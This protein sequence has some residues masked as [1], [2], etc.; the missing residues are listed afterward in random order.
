MTREREI[1]TE[2]NQVTE[3]YWTTHSEYN[4]VNALLI[5]WEDDELNVVPEVKRLQTLFEKDYR[6]NSAPIYPI[7][8]TNSEAELQFEL[9]RFIRQHSLKR[10]SLTIVYYAGH[11]DSP[12]ES[13][14]GYSK[15]RA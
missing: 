8:T 11:A 3:N 12:D 2:F 9:A 10:S 4:E 7:P 6:F 15:W 13:N 14:P 5:H 1:V